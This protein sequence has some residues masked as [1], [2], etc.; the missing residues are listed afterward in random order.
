MIYELL[1]RGAVL[2]IFLGILLAIIV[3]KGWFSLGKNVVESKYYCESE[4]DCFWNGKECV[5]IGTNLSRGNCTCVNHH[6][7]PK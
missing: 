2:F 6:C 1:K 4:E 7:T 3:V 5:S